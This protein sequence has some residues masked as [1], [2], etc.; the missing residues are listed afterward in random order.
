MKTT[1]DASES[2]VLSR[3]R[4]GDEVAI[5]GKGVVAVVDDNTKKEAG[6]GETKAKES[7]KGAE[8]KIIELQTA[9]KTKTALAKPPGRS[10]KQRG[11]SGRTVVKPF[12]FATA[13]RR[14]RRWRSGGDGE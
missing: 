12:R 10:Q 5:R 2:K 11:R 9:T 7:A 8:S 13:R 4:D 3:E 6:E 1:V 14:E